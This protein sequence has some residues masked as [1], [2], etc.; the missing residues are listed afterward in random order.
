ML[1]ITNSEPHAYVVLHLEYF[2]IVKCVVCSFGF[3]ETFCYACS[4][5]SLE[6]LLMFV[7]LLCDR[8][9]GVRSRILSVFRIQ[10]AV[11]RQVD[12]DHV[13]LPMFLLCT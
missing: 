2:V 10:P 8:L 3:S 5:G 1:H 4:F 11:L 12:L 7:Y 13:S 6:C 9:P